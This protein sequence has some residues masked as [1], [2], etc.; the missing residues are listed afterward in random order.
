MFGLFFLLDPLYLVVMGAGIVLSLAANGLVKGAYAKYARVG[1][2]RGYTGAEAARVILA[3]HGIHDVHIE[4]VEGMLSDHYDPRKKVLRLSKNN[5]HGNSLS[6][7]GIAAHEAGHA[8]Q[9]ARAYLPMG[10]RSALVPVANFGAGIG[11]IV[12]IAGLF[13]GSAI[14]LFI[15]KLGILFFAGFLAFQLVTLPVEFNASSRG[16]RALME[17]GIL[18]DKQELRGVSSVLNAA[19][20]TYVAA[21]L[22]TLLMLLYFLLRAGILGGDD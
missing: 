4:P 9:H 6:A 8:V 16:K 5:Y 12:V 13:I 19:A 15:M 18:A 10:I 17:S 20:L 2:A 14:G 7:V 11:P 1:N 21:A 22:G 3:G